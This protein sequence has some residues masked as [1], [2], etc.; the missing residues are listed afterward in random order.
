MH[1]DEDEFPP[2]WGS[3]DG[4]LDVKVANRYSYKLILDPTGE[5]GHEKLRLITE[6]KRPLLRMPSHDFQWPFHANQASDITCQR[7]QLHWK[8]GSFRVVYLMKI[9]SGAAPCSHVVFISISVHST[10]F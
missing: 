2:A 1:S 10:A 4:W 5:F 6:V 3:T 8:Y 9:G 7:R